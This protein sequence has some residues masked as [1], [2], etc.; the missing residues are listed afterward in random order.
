MSSFWIDTLTR[1]QQATGA[2]PQLTADILEAFGDQA[3]NRGKLGWA[4][5]PGGVGVWLNLPDLTASVDAALGLVE[6]VLPGMEFR[7][8]TARHRK[9]WAVKT[10]LADDTHSGRLFDA[11]TPAPAL[12]CALLTAK[13]AEAQPH[14]KED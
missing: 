4:W 12:I 5:R 13:I 14:E 6:R 1:A 10:W 7:I 2:D 11:P 8:S 9:G 3:V